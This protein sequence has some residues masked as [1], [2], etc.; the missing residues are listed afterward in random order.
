MI[1]KREALSLATDKLFEFAESLGLEAIDRRDGYTH[2]HCLRVS[3]LSYRLYSLYVRSLNE[4]ELAEFYKNLEPFIVEPWESRNWTDSLRINYIRSFI[5]GRAANMHDLGKLFWDD[6]LLKSDLRL[7]GQKY[8]TQRL[9][10]PENGVDILYNNFLNIINAFQEN[11]RDMEVQFINALNAWMLVMLFHHRNYDG[12]G[13]PTEIK[14]RDLRDFAAKFNFSTRKLDDSNS[15][16]TDPLRVMVGVLRI[17]DSIDA[18]TSNRRHKVD[19]P[20]VYSDIKEWEREKWYPCIDEIVSMSGTAYHPD[21]VRILDQNRDP[22]EV[23][24]YTKETWPDH[25][26]NDTADCPHCSRKLY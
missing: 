9:M 6:L 18:M 1:P 3:D 24:F 20:K 11:W 5:L 16:D 23:F 7:E 19:K 21:I 14:S 2:H 17:A 26:D 12:G 25:P 10:H 8:Q 22:L 13:Y 4:T 15:V